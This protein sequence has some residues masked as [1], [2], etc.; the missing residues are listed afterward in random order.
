[1]HTLYL[2]VQA[3]LALFSRRLKLN[4]LRV[5]WRYIPF[6]YFISN[7]HLLI[8]L[9]AFLL[10]G[11]SIR[12]PPQPSLTRFPRVEFLCPGVSV[13]VVYPDIPPIFNRPEQP[14]TAT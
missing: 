10:A 1:M 14:F 4:T 11:L 9:V 12:F 8:I 6:G 5:F 7:I 3:L 2:S 13:P